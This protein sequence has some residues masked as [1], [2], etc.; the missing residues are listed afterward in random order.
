MA[1]MRICYINLA[2]TATLTASP[3]ATARMPVTYLQ[4]DA[5][6]YVM[7]AAASGTQV[8]L[9]DWGG[10][11]KTLSCMRLERTNLVDGDTIRL[12]LYSD[13][14]QT[15]QNLDVAAAVA[16]TAGTYSGR[17]WAYSNADRFFAS[18]SAKS[19]KLT[20]VSASAFMCARLFMGAYKEVQ[21]NPAYGFKL[22]PGTNSVAVRRASGSL[23]TNVGAKWR[24]A[25]FDMMVNTEAERAEWAEIGADCGIDK[26]VWISV[27]PGDTNTLERDHSMI[28]HFT[29]MPPQ[30][31]SDFNKWDH[32][33]QVDGI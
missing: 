26:P 16:F 2:D 30:T 19:F 29:S 12:Q 8:I 20:I 17:S 4:N 22:R 33:I 15:V 5:R 27:Y 14:A 25:E 28:V 21:F 10:V 6:D 24:G 13:A 7:L 31:T 9:G 18:T 3:A 11:A 32:S 23:G 1:N